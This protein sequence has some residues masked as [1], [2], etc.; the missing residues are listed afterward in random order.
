MHRNTHS[1]QYAGDSAPEGTFVVG[2]GCMDWQWNN[3][4]EKLFFHIFVEYKELKTVLTYKTGHW[5][6]YINIYMAKIT[7]GD[8][9]TNETVN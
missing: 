9:Q 8:E 6:Y 7:K 3:S 2:W 4:F 1:V 5:K